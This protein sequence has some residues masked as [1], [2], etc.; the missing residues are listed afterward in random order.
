MSPSLSRCR[1]RKPYRSGRTTTIEA[2]ESRALLTPPIITPTLR[3]GGSGSGSFPPYIISHS[4]TFSNEPNGLDGTEIAVRLRDVDFPP[5]TPIFL[6]SAVTNDLTILH[7]PDSPTNTN[8]IFRN[9]TGTSLTGQQLA[10]IQFVPG[11]AL[12]GSTTITVTAFDSNGESTTINIP[13]QLN[14]APALDPL[15]NMSVNEDSPPINIPLAGI[16]AGGPKDTDNPTNGGQ[17]RMLYARSSNVFLTGIPTVLYDAAAMSQ[18][19]TLRFS[20]TR[21]APVSITTTGDNRAFITV[22]I[23]DAGPDNILGKS[24]DP[25][26]GDVTITN[27]NATLDN[28]VRSQRFQF[29]VTPIND[30]PTIDDIPNV[31]FDEDATP[32]IVNLTGITPGGGTS[33]IG[34]ELQQVAINPNITNSGFF[35]LTFDDGNHPYT[36]DPISYNAPAVTSRSETLRITSNSNGGSFTLSLANNKGTTTSLF[37]VIDDSQTTFDID[38]TVG[39]PS[40][41]FVISVDSEEMYVSNVSAN[42]DTFNSN[43]ATVTVVR[44][45]HGT[46]AADHSGDATV[47]E[48]RT[49]NLTVAATTLPSTS[50]TTAISN[51]QTTFN[52]ASGAAFTPPTDFLAADVNVSDTS[53]QVA[54][55]TPFAGLTFPFQISVAGE[56]MTVTGAAEADF[57]VDRTSPVAHTTGDSVRKTLTIRVD[58]EEMI[59]TDIVGNQLTVVRGVNGT[60]NAAHGARPA[61][62]VDDVIN[63]VDASIFNQFFSS[64]PYQIRIGSEDMSVTGVVGNQLQVI[65]GIHGT[66]IANQ[67]SGAIVS[68]LETTGPIAH[69]AT[70]I[71]VQTALEGLNLVQIGDVVVTGGPIG[72]TTPVVVNFAGSLDK[73]NLDNLTADRGNLSG[74]EVQRLQFNGPFSGGGTFTVNFFGT[75]TAI[76]YDADFN[77]I[78]TILENSP[79]MTINPGDIIVTGGPFPGAPVTIQ[80]TGQFANTNVPQ[81][82][83]NSTGLTNDEQQTITILGTPTGGTFRLIYTNQVGT[84]FTTAPI[85]YDQTP[86]NTRT[87][88]ENALEALTTPNTTNVDVVELSSTQWVVTFRDLADFNHQLLTLTQNLLTPASN[89]QIQ[90]LEDG[91]Q[92]V[93]FSTITGGFNPTASVIETTSGALS[94]LDALVDT[95]RITAADIQV[96]GTNLPGL[97]ATV[98]FVG[99]YA[100]IDVAQMT[101]NNAPTP[102]TALSSRS[103]LSANILSTSST[104]SVASAASFPTAPGFTIQIDS[105]EMLVTALAG[106]AFTVNRGINGTTAAAHT[107]GAAVVGFSSAI[108]TTNPVRQF[109]GEVQHLN[110]LAV[111]SN[112]DVVPNPIVIYTSPSTTGSLILTNRR[113]KYG[114]ADITIT[115]IDSGFDQKLSTGS[116]NGITTRTFRVV[117]R[118]VNDVPTIN[119]L[120]DLSIP[121]NTAPFDVLFKGISAGGNEDQ[122]LRVMATSSNSTLLPTPSIDY[123][124]KAATASMHLVP[125]AGQTGTALV[126]VTVEDG[127]NDGLLNTAGDNATRRITFRFDVS[128]NPTLGATLS[129]IT[130]DEDATLQKL[131]LTQVTSGPGE[132]IQPLQLTVSN[133]NTGL[134]VAPSNLNVGPI[135]A[136][137]APLNYKPT[138]KL[139]G[140]DAFHLTLVDGGP[141]KL[142]GTA[143]SLGA[144]ATSTATQ[145]T[146]ADASIYSPIPTHML[147]QPVSSL[148]TDTKVTLSSV[149]AF[150]AIASPTNTFKIQIG[151]EVMTV[152]GVDVPTTTFTVIRGEDSSTIAAHNTNDAV[153]LPFKIQIGTELLRVTTIVGNNLTVVRGIDGST[154]AQHAVSDVVVH[155]NS[156]DNLTITRDINVVVNPVNDLPTLDVIAPNPFAPG[157]LTIPEGSGQQI[158]SLSGITD[159]EGAGARQRLR[160]EASSTNPALTGPITIVYTDGNPTGSIRFTP[161]ANVSGD[162]GITV[163]VFD[164]GADNN[165]N[166]LEADFS[167]KTSRTLNV[168][169]VPIGDAPTISTIANRTLNEDAPLQTVNLVGIS[170]SDANTQDLRV[171]VSTTNTV[172]ISNLT[173]NYNPS[174]LQPST[175][176]TPPATGTVTF[177]PGANHFGS[178]AITVTVTDGGADSR[179]GIDL[180]TNSLTASSSDNEVMITNPTRFPATATPNFNIFIGNEEMTV[181]GIS[182]NTFTVS[183]A[184]NFTLLEIHAIGSTVSAPNTVA[185]NV[186][187]SRTFN[188]TVN[189]INDAPTITTINGTSVVAVLP[190]NAITL[191]AIPEDA[192][193]QTI[194]LAGIGAGPNEFQSVAV[195][196]SS[197]NTGLIVPSVNYVNGNSTGT[198]TFQPVANKSGT[199]TLTVKIMDA[200]P[201]GILATPSDNGV[202]TRNIV[203]NVDAVND[204]PT[205]NAVTPVTVSEESGERTVNLTGITAG[206]G[207]SQI[208]KATAMVVPE[209]SSIAGLITNLS[210]DYTSPNSTG[211]LKFTPGAGLFGTA[212]IRVTV[213]D[214]GF[215]GVLATTARN[216]TFFQ[217]ISV[218]VSNAV[219]PP[220]LAQPPAATINKNGYLI[221]SVEVTGISDGDL[222]TQTLTVTATSDNTDLVPNPTVNFTQSGVVASTALQTATL[223]FNPAVNQLGTANITVTVSDGVGSSVSRMF[224]LTVDD[225]NLPPTIDPIADITDLTEPT[226]PATPAGLIVNLSGITAGG[227][228]SQA[229]TVVTATSSN[230]A[231][232]P[233]PTVTYSSAD[234]TG[235]LSFTPTQDAAGT[236]TIIV[237]VTDAGGNFTNTTFNVVIASDD[238]DTPILDPIA[239]KVIAKSASPTVQTVN[240]AGISD[241]PFESG[242][243]TV[244]VLSNDNTALVPL[245]PGSS[246]NY[247][248]PNSTGTLTFT[249][250]ANTSGVANLMVRVQDLGGTGLTFDQPFSVFVIN[251]PTLAD[252]TNLAGIAEDTLGLQSV[253][254]SGISDGDSGTE[255]VQVSAV[256]LSDPSGIIGSLS[257]TFTNPTDASGSANYTLA[258]DRN[259]TA[260]IQVTVKDQGLTAGFNTGDEATVVKTFTVVVSPVNDAPTVTAPATLTL[261]EDGPT[262][263]INLT[264]IFAKLGALLDES[265]Q[266]LRISASS[267]DTNKVTVSTVNY[268]S[269]QSTGSVIVAPV[270]NAF[271]PAGVPVNVTVTVEDGGTDNNIATPGDNQSFSQVVAVSI[272]A[273]NDLPT[274]STIGDVTIN[275]DPVSFTPVNL[276]GITAGP[277]ESQGL[278][279]TATSDNQFLIPDANLSVIDTSANPTGTLQFTPLADKF[280]DAFIT[281]TVTDDTS[282]DGAAKSFSKTFKVRVNAVNDA[283]EILGLSATADST[284]SLDGT[285]AFIDENLPVGTEVAV[286]D[287]NDEG[288]LSALNVSIIS[289]NTGN[290]FSI[291]N[292]GT[293]RVANAAAINFETNPTFTITVKIVD[294][295][296]VSPTGQSAQQT[297]TINLTDLSEVLTIGSGNW[298]ASGGLTIKRSG[299]MV[300]VLN[301][302]NADVVPAHV[303]ANVTQILVT[304]RSGTADVLT[305]DYSGSFDPI[306]GGTP[307]GLTFNGGAG[308]GDTLKFANATFGQLDTTFSSPTS[309]VI[310]DPAAPISLT[311]IEAITFNSSVTATNLNFVYG[312]GNDVVTFADDGN[313]GNGVS[314]FSASS[315]PLVTFPAQAGVTVDVGGGNNSVTFNSIEDAAGP[316]VTVLAGDGLDSLRASAVSRAVSL[317]GGGGNDTLAG[318]SGADTLDGGEGDDTISG[319][320]GDDQIFGGNGTNTLYESAD[321]SFSVGN[322]TT[323]G[324]LGSDN[325]SDIALAILVG[326]AGH[327]TI[328]ADG[329]GGQT[330]INGGGGNDNLTGSSQEDVITGGLGDDTIDGGGSDDTL[331]E[332]G[333]FNFLLGASTMTGLGSDSLT[334]IEFAVLT[335]GSGNNTLDASGFGGTVTLFGGAGND[336]LKGGDGDDSVSGDA[337]NDTL[338]GNGGTNTLNGGSEIDQVFEM[339]NVD[340]TLEGTVLTAQLT[341]GLST[342]D[343]IAIET[344]KLV[345][346]DDNNRLNASMFSGKTTLQGGNGADTLIGGSNADSLE[347]GNGDDV[348]TGGLGNDKLVGGANLDTIVEDNLTGLTMTA[349][350]MTATSA[351]GSSTDTL[352]SMEAG[353]FTGTAAGNT[354]SGGTFAGALTI[355][356]LEGNDTLTGGAGS[357]FIY[358]RAGKDR[359]SGGAGNDQIDGGTENDTISGLAGND[360]ILGGDGNDSILG[361]DGDDAIDGQAGD[362]KVFG[363]NGNDIL[364]GGIGKDSINGGAGNDKL[365]SGDYATNPLDVS[366]SDK[367]TLIS[368][369][370]ADTVTGD[371][372]VDLDVMTDAS[373]TAAEKAAAF[374]IDYN[375]IFGALLGP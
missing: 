45:Y 99:A 314:T 20:P 302:S 129:P 87:N 169:V 151:S 224:A 337:G 229:L 319:G 232:I 94:L 205:L 288:P 200:G 249:P 23:E 317:S 198:I 148:L 241:G 79:G 164:G 256:V 30:P 202:T 76:P 59:V 219:D 230:T 253:S 29:T 368:G 276:A 330:T 339:G 108:V 363:D 3:P 359:L 272:T 14:D 331:I 9:E 362:D 258:A 250:A 355:D 70:A 280:G 311:G 321:T 327:N 213:E 239:N 275:E 95:P 24:Y 231:A 281:V 312:T 98:A 237:T 204:A 17:H 299:A 153:V 57:S 162:A 165:L 298:P 193:L 35:T 81:M 12:F 40:T 254:L 225:V 90:T 6:S 290:A 307:G 71:E 49:T 226:F 315:S 131:N 132:S 1:S 91:N 19:G 170:D 118:P 60:S 303:F 278:T 235:T 291:G 28:L 326:G 273:A 332:T 196:V 5:D 103:N 195:S 104:L 265:G 180:L 69:N 46:T 110:V 134:F 245:L 206:G 119:G 322:S 209:S 185:D 125:S 109:D 358:G 208:L 117:V 167:D 53:I 215:D 145:I 15:T 350:S 38:D 300:Q 364:I 138:A 287:F 286:V 344:A 222:N 102:T 270:A 285:T 11:T 294:N 173:L 274:L 128:E 360:T 115:V 61:M 341:S 111:S 73:I 147:A 264:N 67:V 186:S 97:P 289:G 214:A 55:A 33:V 84:Q 142:L 268:T 174:N 334:R 42:P 227:N 44:G 25:N 282:I 343:L 16:T 189:P 122:D 197:N 255:G 65:R 369:A 82:T 21:G 114:E 266:P 356:G 100:G 150:P 308:A 27:F 41:P 324:G 238:N 182:G 366:D 320:Q 72:P 149:S 36:T 325:F 221:N 93:G 296:P 34:N 228:E 51:V 207:E 277:G 124:N 192:P 78:R 188:V 217:D 177:V 92:V 373:N 130:L 187:T 158:I 63:V 26:N 203:V 154:P 113:D 306:P 191:P 345:G 201:D 351:A 48:L 10:Y 301:S 336:I 263:T 18:I 172:L 166:T 242:S 74:D 352:A 68:P 361:G 136:N 313:S 367:D 370:G 121:K 267:A 243:V 259:G 160:I 141:D 157:T 261:T 176:G 375:N 88:I 159:G 52:V 365:W 152:I 210:L 133:T 139:S 234:P 32:T 161:T 354:L 156:L 305:L 247:T 236:F 297:F 252:I 211:V 155:P 260:T 357:D 116:D 58:R 329:F 310:N 374:I 342:D 371:G 269:A 248:S 168:T 179:L 13:V 212:T 107:A 101:V 175:G 127:G 183:R 22:F 43:R 77:T 251:P 353:R 56:L 47:V 135:A 318:G 316:T 184:V 140:S 335:G 240:L 83:V 233:N 304:G 283:P 123:T 80:F 2:L 284:V 144:A 216:A 349:G 293:I 126:V 244:T 199:A 106:S 194:N 137:S 163:T 323:S 190:P 39:F 8:L 7:S 338:S 86:G 178:A 54:D 4:S 50:L 96:T 85:T 62:Q 171:T 112:P 262:G 328:S 220:T 246:A 348:L 271:T 143:G 372:G 181:T 75:S 31:M 37:D 89:V 347:G 218:I 257:T 120:P 64:V 292:D 295:S 340:F 146:V 279:V 223:V 346:G 333:N 309:A 105:E 66:I